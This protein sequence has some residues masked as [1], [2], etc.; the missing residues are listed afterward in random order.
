MLRL[1]TGQAMERTLST[2]AVT[3]VAREGKPVGGGGLVA[4][5]PPTPLPAMGQMPVSFRVGAVERAAFRVLCYGDSLTVGFHD[6][7]RSYEPYGRT[8]AEALSAAMGG[9]AVEVSVCGQSGHTAAEMVRNADS[10]TVEDIGGLLSKGLRRA[11]ADQPGR[12]DLVAIMAGTNDLGQKSRP[13]VVLEHLR[14]LHAMC[15]KQGVPT[16]VLAPPAAP[17]APPGTAF[18]DSR[19]TL[20]A[21]LAAWASTACGAGA[22]VNPAEL[23]PAAAR[24]CMWD[25][26][27]LH[28][29][30]AGSQYLGQR[31]AS[32][33]VP[34]LLKSQVL[35]EAEDTL[36]YHL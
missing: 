31:L 16:V 3:P 28:F 15:H 29:S 8:L 35:A 11:L 22:F 26:D 32:V 23:V 12:L 30:P 19:R 5:P 24:S 2:A 9:V 6:N 13:K 33:L 34:L 4:T 27:G 10:A 17:K 18:E 14:Q 20:L 25:V 1:N 7:G 21:L 36:L